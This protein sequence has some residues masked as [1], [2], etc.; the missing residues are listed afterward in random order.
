METI[1]PRWTRAD[2][3]R[4]GHDVHALECDVFGKLADDSHARQGVE[5]AVAEND[6]LAARVDGAGRVT[7]H[8]AKLKLLA[9]GHAAGAAPESQAHAPFTQV[10]SLRGTERIPPV[11]SPTF[12]GFRERLLHHRPP[13]PE[14]AAPRETAPLNGIR[15]TFGH[16]DDDVVGARFKHTELGNRRANHVKVEAGVSDVLGVVVDQFRHAVA[17]PDV[18]VLA[19]DQLQMP[20]VLD[21]NADRPR[22]VGCAS[23][24]GNEVAQFGRTVSPEL[25]PAR[26]ELDH[27]RLR[28]RA[29]NVGLKGLV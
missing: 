29:G 26:R 10:F 16:P 6:V 1:G 8:V 22:L 3:A 4:T 18:A 2:S 14:V 24:V 23:G 7:F 21:Q 19:P 13:R 20:G 17:E 12:P 9:L 25:M 11:E 15:R 5:I 27:D 28:F